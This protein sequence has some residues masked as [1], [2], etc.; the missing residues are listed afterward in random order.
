[1]PIIAPAGVS[2]A[3]VVVSGACHARADLSVA[4][5]GRRFPAGLAVEVDAALA[6]TLIGLGAA[7]ALEEAPSAPNVADE[8][9]AARDAEPTTKARRKTG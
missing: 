8:Q 4:I 2:Q 7:V 3:G 9:A 5:S 1:M 6:K